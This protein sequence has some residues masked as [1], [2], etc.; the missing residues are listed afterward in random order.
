M[1]EKE[2]P[3]EDEVDVAAQTMLSIRRML[4][5]V[6]ME[7]LKAAIERGAERCRNYIA[8]G[9]LVDPTDY[10]RHGEEIKNRIEATINAARTLLELKKIWHLDVPIDERIQ[11]ELDRGA[12]RH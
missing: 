1:G 10:E 6:P 11:E 9:P 4:A 3:S 12:P 5:T 7:I 2:M 8:M